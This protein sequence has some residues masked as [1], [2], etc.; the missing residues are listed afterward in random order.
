MRKPFNPLKLTKETEKMVCKGTSRK[1]WDFTSHR[2]IDI[3]YVHPL[4][5][6]CNLRCV[7]CFTPK[8]VRDEPHMGLETLLSPQ[9]II[10]KARFHFKKER[11][12]YKGKP[13][14]IVKIFNI[15]GTEPTVG[16]QHLIKLASLAENEESIDYFVIDTN[17]IL[18]GADKSYVSSL[19]KYPKC[20]LCLGLKA[21]TPERFEQIT[22][23]QARFYDLPFKAIEYCLDYKL[24][25][26]L[27]AMTDPR[28]MPQKEKEAL[29]SKL[30]DIDPFL[31]KAARDQI[32]LPFPIAIKRLEK[33][34]YKKLR[35]SQAEL[36]NVLLPELLRKLDE[37][38]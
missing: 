33:A 23:A 10:D 14:Q 20:M 37:D 22:G 21:G 27:C 15:T 30:C 32:L 12:F 3:A 8:E 31:E 4:V 2:I 24:K 7:F 26:N 18:L 29:H 34:G 28:I 36:T 9:Q 38:F 6:G 5:A 35:F 16:R 25:F 1:Y 11:A 13:Y 17:G 19:S